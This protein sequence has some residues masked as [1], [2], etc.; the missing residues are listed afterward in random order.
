MFVKGTNNNNNNKLNNAV[1]DWMKDVA[2]M[3][4]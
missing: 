4:F 2:F 1:P 3:P